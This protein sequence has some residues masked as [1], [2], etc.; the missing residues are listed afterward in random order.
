M[1]PFSLEEYLANPK[2]KLVTRDGREVKRI[3]CTD[4]K[5]KYPI[6]VVIDNRD[7]NTERAISLTKDGKFFDGSSD[8]KDIFFAPEKHE[9][10]VNIFKV[11]NIYHT[12]DEL[13]YNSKK[14]AEMQ[15]KN[16]MSYIDTVKI[17]WE[18]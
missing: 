6:V 15:G 10:W 3:L 4:V 14:E 16:Y 7:G 8:N 13:V 12:E 1:K 9:G 2:K 11:N 17:E 18:E 5:G